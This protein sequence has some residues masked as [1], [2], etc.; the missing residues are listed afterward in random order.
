MA[1]GL[2]QSWFTS[3]VISTVNTSTLSS[4]ARPNNMLW[5]VRPVR[6]TWQ[7]L[8][9]ISLSIDKR[10]FTM[11]QQQQILY[12][13]QPGSSAQQAYGSDRQPLL[14]GINSDYV[15]LYK[16]PTGRISSTYRRWDASLTAVLQPHVHVVWL[17]VNKKNMQHPWN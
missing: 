6:S 7:I 4:E 17:Q 15:T 14:L 3:K 16:E 1:T 13:S 10:A 9:K 11:L 12:G 2:Q 5:W 8:S